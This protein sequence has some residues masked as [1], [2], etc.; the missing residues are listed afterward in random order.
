MK[1]PILEKPYKGEIQVMAIMSKLRNPVEAQTNT[2]YN[3]IQP[4][5]RLLLQISPLLDMDAS[6]IAFLLSQC[7]DRA[8]TSIQVTRVIKM[9]F[10]D[11]QQND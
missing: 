7:M 4:G 2:S 5:L 11:L 9:G 3:S 1:I 8:K 10:T 6:C